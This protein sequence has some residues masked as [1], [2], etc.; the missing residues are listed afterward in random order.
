MSNSLDITSVNMNIRP[1]DLTRIE[2]HRGTVQQTLGGAWMDSFGPGVSKVNIS[3]TTGW[4]GSAGED[5]VA[6]FKKLNDTVFNS[7]FEKRQQAILKGVDPNNVRLIFADLLD[8]FVYVVSPDS[9]VLRRNKARPL[10]MQYQISMTVLSEDLDDLKDS[11]RPPAI[12]PDSGIAIPAALKQL[13]EILAKIR[14]WAKDIAKFISGT[15]GVVAKAFMELTASVLAVVVET[16]E[17]LK[18]SIDIVAESLLSVASD[19]AQAGWN[20]MSAIMQVRS[21]ADYAKMRAMEVSA[22]F[23]YA[24]CLLSNAFNQPK[25][26]QTYTDWYGASNCSALNGGSPP[27][28][29]RFENPFYRMS[30]PSSAVPIS[31]STDAR[32]SLASLTSIDTMSPPS[33]V[34][35]EADMA[36]VTAGTSVRAV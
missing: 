19:L 18:G 34:A 2:P 4:R 35:V 26:Y 29:L 28:P 25:M 31:Q 15:I 8:D 6:I 11:L 9:F 17:S 32:Q 27:S 13:R 5:G 21:L 12:L 10:L 14:G 22:A 7:W 20:I 1:E 30:T 3:G 36:S 23:S 24:W 16:V 33:L